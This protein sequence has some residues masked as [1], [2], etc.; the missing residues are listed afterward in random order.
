MKR[1]LISLALLGLAGVA[2]AAPVALPFTATYGSKAWTATKIGGSYDESVFVGNTGATS[3]AAIVQF[4]QFVNG[5][6]TVKGTGLTNTWGLYGLFTSDAQQTSPINFMGLSGTFSLYLDKN[7]DSNGVLTAGT[8]NTI[9]TKPT[10]SASN[11]SDDV[12]LGSSVLMRTTGTY[13]SYGNTNLPASFDFSF[14]NFS[15]TS[16]GQGF[17]TSPLPFYVTISSTGTVLGLNGPGSNS[18][19]GELN[20]TFS[21]DRSIPE[22]E[23]LALIG[24]G[25]VGLVA[26]RRRKTA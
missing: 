4:G 14:D 16:D 7:N 20:V 13:A 1:T 25:L 5:P 10:V 22:P 12:L 15:L 2:S 24:L 3:A 9:G 19:T 8:G 26:T 21:N 18:V 11:N 17:F 6:T 23:S